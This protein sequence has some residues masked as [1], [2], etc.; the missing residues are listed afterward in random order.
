MSWKQDEIRA[1]KPAGGSKPESGPVVDDDLSRRK[2]A[3]QFYRT[4]P[5]YC[6]Q[7]ENNGRVTLRQ[8]SYEYWE[9]QEP[10]QATTWVT[11]S[12]HDNLEEAERRL[13]LI[14]TPGSV[15][16]LVFSQTGLN[17]YP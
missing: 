3:R 13:R 5:P 4:A 11:I 1:R 15:D 16:S 9:N 8:K 17:L 6:I 12:I 14:P 7:F 2:L 10:E